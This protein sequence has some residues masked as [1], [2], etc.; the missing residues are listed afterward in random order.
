MNRLAISVAGL[1]ILSSALGRGQDQKACKDRESSSRHLA[2]DDFPA[3]LHGHDRADRPCKGR[4]GVADDGSETYEPIPAPRVRVCRG[5]RELG[6]EPGSAA[7]SPS[8]RVPTGCGRSGRSRYQ[9]V[10]RGM[11]AGLAKT[12]P[13]L[14]LSE[15]RRQ[16]EPW[17]RAALSQFRSGSVEKALAAFE[18][19]GLIE[20]VATLADVR[21]Q[22]VD[23]W[24]TARNNG[25]EPIILAARR[26]AFEVGVGDSDH[27][28]SV[29]GKGR[30]IPYRHSTLV[31]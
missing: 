23:A 18:S 10:V 15:N 21:A 3:E 26:E 14:S 29:G 8:A 12:V 13:V 2:A 25:E 7:T 22:I 1:L 4:A 20:R 11:L 30:S 5:C 9:L 19:H 28:A 17:E 16:R 24:A 6:A 27:S 31:T